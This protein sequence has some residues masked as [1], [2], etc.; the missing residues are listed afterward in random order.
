MFVRLGEPERLAPKSQSQWK[1]WISSFSLLTF[2][3]KTWLSQKLLNCTLNF[4][5]VFLKA[6]INILDEENHFGWGQQGQ[7]WFW[8]INAPG[9]KGCVRQSSFLGITFLSSHSMCGTLPRWL[10]LCLSNSVI[11][12]AEEAEGDSLC[13]PRRAFCIFSNAGHS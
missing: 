10:Q 12:L 13:L 8:D 2:S 3:L 5:S 1:Y 7:L 9:H 4:Y 11:V 6:I